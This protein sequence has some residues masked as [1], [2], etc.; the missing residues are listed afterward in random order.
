MTD[1]RYSAARHRYLYP[2]G[3]AVSNSRILAAR[4]GFIEGQE[5]AADDL[6]ALL[7]AGEMAV[8]QWE[9]DVR[10]LQKRTFVAEFLL[11]AGGR[12]MVTSRGWGSVGGLL[13]G[14]YRYLREFAREVAA[15]E[16]SQ[17]QI[18]ARTKLY[19]AS[20]TQAYERGKAAGY[21]GLQLPVYPAD[22]GT[23]CRARCRCWWDVQERETAWHA[24]YRTSAGETCVDCVGR[25]RLYGPYI[26]EKPAA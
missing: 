8:A 23:R 21:A 25:S 7:A 5:A 6:A 12:H 9:R 2:D 17:A 19:L 26:Q 20:A 4:Q 15:G 22:G 13:A 3:R 11:G 16:L 24:F 10:A 18:A 1:W 14:Q